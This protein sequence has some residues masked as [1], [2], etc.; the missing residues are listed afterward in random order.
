MKS[1]M[2]TQKK[3][4][5][6]L[7]AIWSI[8]VYYLTLFHFIP[9]D[10]AQA[11]KYQLSVDN[12]N[13]THIIVKVLKNPDAPQNC[14]TP[15]DMKSIINEYIAFVFRDDY[16]EIKPF[17][18]NG[19]VHEALYLFAVT[20]DDQNYILDFVYIDSPLAYQMVKRDE[21]TVTI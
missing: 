6:L 1:L 15:S 10:T 2:I 4:I 5:L 9:S 17:A 14:Y 16:P 18:F 13:A 3:F 11:M 7:H 21:S 8:S 12:C 20:D 19:R